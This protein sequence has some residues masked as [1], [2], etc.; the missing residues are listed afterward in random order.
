MG[1]W[2]V[3]N[4]TSCWELCREKEIICGPPLKILTNIDL[5]LFS[6]SEEGSLVTD[7]YKASFHFIYEAEYHKQFHQA[8]TSLTLSVVRLLI[9]LLKQF[10]SIVATKIKLI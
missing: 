6:I 10:P 8:T 5:L 1:C 4:C 3:A 7:L 2:Q 9:W